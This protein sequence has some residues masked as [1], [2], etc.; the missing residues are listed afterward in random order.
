MY[1]VLL[2]FKSYA[3]YKCEIYTLEAIMDHYGTTDG[4]G[5]HGAQHHVPEGRPIGIYWLMLTL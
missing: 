4:N 1:S 2:C 5:K 3:R